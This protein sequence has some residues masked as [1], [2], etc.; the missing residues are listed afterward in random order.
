MA[1]EVGRYPREFV[2]CNE[3]RWNNLADNSRAEKWYLDLATV[4]LTRV[5]LVE[6]WLTPDFS[7]FKREK[8][9]AVSTDQYFSEICC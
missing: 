4:I 6:F 7:G 8:S 9:E 3:E 1:S 2:S 5:V